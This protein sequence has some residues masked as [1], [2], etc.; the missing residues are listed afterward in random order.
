MPAF[1]LDEDSMRRGLAEALR[2]A[3]FDCLTAADAANLGQSDPEQLAYAASHGLVLYTQNVRDF[4]ILHFEWTA[5]SRSHAGIIALG[6]QRASIGM[7]VRAVQRLIEMEADIGLD[8]RF[9]YL[10]NYRD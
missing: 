8:N 9:F 6:D 7:Q 1:Y 2:A 10:H 3:G 4:R 5:S